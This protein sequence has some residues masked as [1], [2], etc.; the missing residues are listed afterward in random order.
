MFSGRRHKGFRSGTSWGSVV[1][2][3]IGGG[4]GAAGS[5]GSR[6]FLLTVHQNDLE[7]AAY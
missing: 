5:G 1:V 3:V 2:T 6:G 7:V 4:S